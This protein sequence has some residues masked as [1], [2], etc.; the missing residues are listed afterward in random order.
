MEETMLHTQRL[1]LRKWG[2]AD[3]DSLFEY[4]K[5]PDV[6]LSAGWPPHESKAES[7]EVIKNVLNGT[8][9]YAICKKGSDKA[10]GPIELRPIVREDGTK[11]NDERELGFWLGKPFWETAICPRPRRK[12]SGMV[13][14]IL[15]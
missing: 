4:A 6:G 1:V 2:E 15:V 8:E 11:R 10:I 14:R 7:L 5:D 9:R 13:L 12:S 3:A